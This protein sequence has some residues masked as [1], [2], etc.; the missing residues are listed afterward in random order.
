MNAIA[1]EDMDGL[2][3]GA[4]V[5]LKN[6]NVKNKIIEFNLKNILTDLG[7][8]HDQYID[9]SILSG[10]D[11]CST[12]KG[13]GPLTAYKLIQENKD[14]EGVLKSIRDKKNSKYIYDETAFDFITTRKLFKNPVA[15]DPQ[16]IKVLFT[17]TKYDALEDFLC[18]E[19][20]FGYTRVKKAIKKLKEL[21]SVIKN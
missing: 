8:T 4:P 3:F 12:I 14:L 11:Y 6:F 16:S 21:E 2:T 13:I 7:L 10:C 20:L 9:L 18:N 19:K 1:T 5:M 15:S 17:K